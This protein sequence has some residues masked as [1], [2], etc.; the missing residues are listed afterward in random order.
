MKYFKFE[1]MGDTLFIKGE[2]QAAATDELTE[3]IG[4]VPTSMLTITEIQEA[5][6]PDDEEW[7]NE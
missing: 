6:L 7:L 2:D 5:D 1:A 3:N 4:P